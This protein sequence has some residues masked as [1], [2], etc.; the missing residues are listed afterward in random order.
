MKLG[1]QNV[2]A[3]YQCQGYQ[4]VLGSPDFLSMRLIRNGSLVSI[5]AGISLSD[6]VV[7]QWVAS[8]APWHTTTAKIKD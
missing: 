4:V 6:I 1:I 8:I 2:L 7:F 3:C 5:S